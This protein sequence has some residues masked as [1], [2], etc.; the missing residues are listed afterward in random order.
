MPWFYRGLLFLNILYCSLGLVTK[1]LPAWRMFEN[2]T[3][4]DFRLIDSRG[5]AIEIQQYLPTGAYINNLKEALPIVKFICE[6]NHDRAPLYFSE[7]FSNIK[8]EVGPVDC[9]VHL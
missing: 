8:T 5:I 6:K 4:L 2:V 3:P 1:K 7:T 9:E